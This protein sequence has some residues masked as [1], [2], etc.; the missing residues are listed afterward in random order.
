MFLERKRRP[1]VDPSGAESSAA[2]T[3]SQAN[4]DV[5]MQD[6][7][8]PQENETTANESNARGRA[9][10]VRMESNGATSSTDESDTTSGKIGVGLIS[11]LLLGE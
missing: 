5:E 9:P 10:L 11:S 2:G 6:L 3:E 1:K 7:E 4:D 8:N